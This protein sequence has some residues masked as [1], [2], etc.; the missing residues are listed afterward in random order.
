MTLSRDQILAANDLEVREVDVPEW[1]GT[2]KVRALNGAERDRFEASL[3]KERR[4]A[5][6]KEG[7]EVVANTDNM[8]A[9]LVAR[10]VVD[11]DGKRV[12]TDADIN[13]LGEKS[14]LV[15]DRLFD[16]VS[17]LSG[18]SDTAAEEAEKNS[19]S[20]LSDS[21]TTGSLATTGS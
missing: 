18:L 6:G 16:V 10:A 17:D 1:G 9:K 4:R 3:R 14:A 12:F 8:R 21:S 13:A 2:V 19:E 15:L 20:D 7:T 5:D 11:D